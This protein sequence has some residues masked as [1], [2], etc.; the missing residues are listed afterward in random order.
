MLWTRA[1]GWGTRSG[2]HTRFP[3]P[4]CQHRC[5]CP[6]HPNLSHCHLRGCLQ[7]STCQL[8]DGSLFLG[9]I[10]SLSPLPLA[11][12]RCRPLPSLQQNSKISRPAASVQQETIEIILSYFLSSP[13]HSNIRGGKTELGPVCG[14]CTCP[15]SFLLFLLKEC[16]AENTSPWLACA[17]CSRLPFPSL[18]GLEG[19][20]ICAPQTKNQLSVPAITFILN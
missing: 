15:L 6:E 13:N 3:R 14:P 16:A 7:P 5:Y 20:D 8:V 17:S 12:L 4:H 11:C 2:G 19:F 18:P 1:R 9:P 10:R